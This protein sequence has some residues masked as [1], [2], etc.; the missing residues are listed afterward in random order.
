MKSKAFF[1]AKLFLLLFAIG[2]F[3][4]CE[5][6][7]LIQKN[8]ELRKRVSELEK[9]VDILQINAGENPGDQTASIKQ[10]NKDLAKALG[11]LEQLDAEKEKLEEAHAKMEKELRDYQRKYQ[12]K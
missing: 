1:S 9:E 3:S 4:S 5:D 8:E 2:S 10:A 6:K 12:I 7:A 11:E